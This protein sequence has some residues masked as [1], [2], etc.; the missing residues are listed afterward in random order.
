MH[1]ATIRTEIAS[2]APTRPPVVT[3][4]E[5]SGRPHPLVDGVAAQVAARA[6]QLAEKEA[7][8][9]RAV[10]AIEQAR[11]GVGAEHQ[12]LLNLLAD[13]LEHGADP[14]YIAQAAS[15][16]I[17]ACTDSPEPEAGATP[18]SKLSAACHRR[19][20]ALA[21]AHHPALTGGPVTEPTVRTVDDCALFL[22]PVHWDLAD[23]LNQLQAANQ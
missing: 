6:D 21:F 9:T 14:A 18:L 11:E 1:F 4:P 19:G 8:H 17:P 5:P 10:A 13:E 2:P 20:L 15:R 22:V 23:A 7:A 3:V 16:V 12:Y